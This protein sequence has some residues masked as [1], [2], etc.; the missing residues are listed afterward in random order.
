[1]TATDLEDVAPMDVHAWARHVVGA[2][3]GLEPDLRLLTAPAR[4]PFAGARQ[5]VIVDL[6]VD[7][8]AARWEADQARCHHTT[9]AVAIDAPAACAGPAP[10]PCRGLAQGAG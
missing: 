9:T 2:L 5:H 6:D 10:G 7:A 1:M 3:A 8:L 4:R